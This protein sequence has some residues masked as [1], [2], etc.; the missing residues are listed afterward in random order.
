MGLLGFHGDRRDVKVED[1]VRLVSPDVGTIS[2]RLWTLIHHTS[3]YLEGEYFL[4]KFPQ[5]TADHLKK[6]EV[7]ISKDS[8][9]TFTF[10]INRGILNVHTKCTNV[11]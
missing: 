3:G 11:P 9:I 5:A 7:Q 4:L 6:L 8:V 10:R 1:V 2:R